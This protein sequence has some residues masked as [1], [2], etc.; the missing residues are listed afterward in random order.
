V[1]KV[2]PALLSISIKRTGTGT[3]GSGKLPR[4]ISKTLLKRCRA[5]FLYNY[6]SRGANSLLMANKM[7]MIRLSGS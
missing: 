4:Y 5:I 2:A 7:K 1:I 3:L 6:K